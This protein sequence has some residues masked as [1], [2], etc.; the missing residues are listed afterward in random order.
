VNLAKKLEDDAFPTMEELEE[1]EHM[2]PEEDYWSCQ[3]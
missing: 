1:L 2:G 3:E